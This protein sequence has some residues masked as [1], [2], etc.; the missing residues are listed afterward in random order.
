M[1]ARIERLEAAAR[2]KNENMS[3]VS[4]HKLTLK[5]AEYTAVRQVL[6]SNTLALSISDRFVWATMVRSKMKVKAEKENHV[7]LQMLLNKVLAPH[8]FW[9]LLSSTSVLEETMYNLTEETAKRVTGHPDAYIFDQKDV[10]RLDVEAG[11]ALMDYALGVVKWKR[12]AEVV[13]EGSY[14]Q[15]CFETLALGERLRGRPV[16][17]L[18]TDQSQ[19]A[20]VFTFH[21]SRGRYQ[22]FKSKAAPPIGAKQAFLM[23]LEV[24]L[25]EL[26]DWLK[27]STKCIQQALP[28]IPE[29]E[30]G[31]GGSA[32]GAAGGSDGAGGGSGG[33]KKMPPAGGR[34]SG[35]SSSSV[36]N[37]A[38][39]GGGTDSLATIHLTPPKAASTTESCLAADEADACAAVV[40]EYAEQELEEDSWPTEGGDEP[41]CLSWHNKVP[42]HLAGHLFNDSERNASG[43]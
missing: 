4:G 28:V 7:N 11:T 17:G 42:A 22:E 8:G 29:E 13:T 15:V 34:S 26:V 35:E 41:L 14:A 2:A 40:G 36:F 30:G 1:E 24:A 37:A 25:C 23:P 21:A 6:C 38:A 5:K 27:A 3:A 20:A 43:R 32:G 12:P 9:A 31:H 16:I 19:A 33:A 10:P 18:L 39:A